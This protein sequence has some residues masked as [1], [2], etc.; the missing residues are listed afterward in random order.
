M[1]RSG[2][3][4]NIN[5]SYFDDPVFNRKMEQAQLKTGAARWAAYAKLDRELTRAAP[6]VVYGN[7]TV[8]EFTSERIGCPMY[9]VPTGGLNLAMLCL[10][11]K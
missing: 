2:K 5:S 10:R 6:I 3:Q 9:S 1:A 8:R 7:T 11:Q 4:N